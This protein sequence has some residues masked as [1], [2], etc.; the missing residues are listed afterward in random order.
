MSF[1]AVAIGVGAVG[2]VVGGAIASSGASKAAS[3][4]AKGAE[5]AAQLQKQAADAALAEQQ[6][7]FDIGQS[8]LQPWLTQG[9]TGL[10][11]LSYLLGLMP[12]TGVTTGTPI[13]KTVA[14]TATPVGT[15]PAG[16]STAATLASLGAD[17]SLGGGRGTQGM[18]RVTDA[19]LPG[20][21]ATGTVP[22]ATP[23]TA[24]TAPETTATGAAG[25]P[26]PVDLSTLV[27]PSLG[28]AGSLMAP[29]TEKFTAPT[30][31]TEQN[32]P[33]YQF[34]LQQGLKALQNSAAASGTLLSGGTGKALQ[35]YGQDYASNEY[36]NV[37]NRALGQYQQN[38]NIFKQ[39]Q[40][41]Q[42]NRLAAMSGVGQ[43]AANTLGNLGQ[44]SAANISN[45][46][47]T[48]GA[49]QAQQAN[50]AAAARASG[51]AAGGNIWGNAIGGSTNSLMNM[52]LMNKLL[53]PGGATAYNNPEATIPTFDPSM[54]LGVG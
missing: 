12:T 48:S 46:L 13:G 15:A 2:S 29:W 8:N 9:R 53:S 20:V 34:R 42:F 5:Y 28:A 1:V 44:S 3:T 39:N 22:G 36:G 33:G 23:A 40:A 21:N 45:I 6:R 54:S 31:V 47:M 25:V 49:Q 30:N 52:Y 4:Q 10:A 7:Q 38:Y 37:Y 26:A 35:R 43:T 24:T 16:G 27:N 18:P 50:N 41:D 17:N 11:N 19:A 32:D 14:D 51:Y